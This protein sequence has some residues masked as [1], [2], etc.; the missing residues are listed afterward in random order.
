MLP[1]LGFFEG[2]FIVSAILFNLLIAGIFIADRNGSSRW[3]SRL[4]I[5]WLLLA[6]PLALAFSYFLIQGAPAWVLLAFG[7]VFLYMLLELLLDY[8]FKYDF[9]KQWRT[10]VPYILLEYLALFSLIAIAIW[11]D[12]TWGWVVSGSFWI[13]LACLI[14]LYARR[15]KTS[16]K[17]AAE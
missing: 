4:G 14:Y 12:Q 7:L 8:I 5:A 10:H 2:L 16:N 15:G 3:I 6:L 17:P 13:M 11:I 9:R 1:A